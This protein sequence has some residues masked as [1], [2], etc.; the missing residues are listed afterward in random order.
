VYHC[1]PNE[2]EEI[3]EGIASLHFQYLMAERKNERI[4]GKK[5][6][7]QARVKGK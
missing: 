4:E 7:Q 5:A 3:P 6:E 2:L 1:T